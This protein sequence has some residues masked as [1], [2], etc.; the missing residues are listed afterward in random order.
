MKACKI[1]WVSLK[2]KEWFNSPDISQ[3]G[4]TGLNKAAVLIWL[5]TDQMSF[6]DFLAE[7]TT[8]SV[9]EPKAGTIWLR[10]CSANN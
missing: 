6:P 10:R 1:A 7:G 2:G 3:V 9:K 5:Q 8:Y 4:E